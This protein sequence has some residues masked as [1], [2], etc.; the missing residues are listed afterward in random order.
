MSRSAVSKRVRFEVFKRDLFACQ[1]CGQNPP[2][3]VLH[4]DHIH[5]VAEGGTNE[6]DNL[7]TSCMD[8]NLGKGARLLTSVPE[9]L[10]SKAADIEEREAQL[11][12][13]RQIMDDK[14]DRLE[15][16]TWEVVAV[17][18]PGADKFNRR[19]LLS[20]KRFIEKLGV[21]AVKEAAEIDYVRMPHSQSRMFRYFCGICWGRIRDMNEGA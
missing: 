3:V 11:A 2:N 20:I 18:S 16:E 21:Y 17:L 8:C 4:C 15:D 10:A 13:Y 12:G 5:P 6:I 1:Y 19:D 14:A 9:S 7:V